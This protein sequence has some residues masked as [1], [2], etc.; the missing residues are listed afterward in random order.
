[1]S[2]RLVSSRWR[3]EALSQ[4]AV[5][6][7]LPQ[8]LLAG[9]SAPGTVEPDSPLL[10]TDDFDQAH[11]YVTDVYIPHDLQTRD[12]GRLDFK[13]RYL[14]SERLTL[15]HLTYG[16]DSELI[17]PPMLSCYHV[18][19]TLYGETMVCQDGG[20]A[21]TSA[22]RSGVAVSPTDPF[23]VRWSPSAVQYAVKFPRQPLENQ[24]AK[25]IRR[26]V[27]KPIRF[28]LGFDLTTA[29]GG[30]LLAAVTFL[31]EQLARPGGL[32]AMP[33]AR[34][35]L[36][37]YVLSALLMAVPNDYSDVLAAPSQPARKAN[38][39]RVVDLIEADPARDLS[40]PEL[41]AIAGVSARALQ[42]GFR[43]VVGTSPTQ[44]VRSV[45]LER[46]HHD[47]VSEAGRHTVSDVAMRWGFFHMS[48]FATQ[49][50][51]RFGVT[52]SQTVKLATADHGHSPILDRAI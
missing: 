24:L 31:R 23:T 35:Q 1:M 22:R 16:A 51:A 7:S 26:D 30:S 46:V 41:A 38:I 3:A 19:L 44:Y 37:S 15:G 50:R 12:P 5:D 17:V 8:H 18:N 52:P 43:E 45:R 10:A 47:L 39:Q 21:Q 48:R 13:L 4:S 11:E 6:D 40:V 27:D 2:K 33:L 14:E 42:A 32:A 29:A 36:E 25:H 34:E 9:E 20:R 49:Y 28:D